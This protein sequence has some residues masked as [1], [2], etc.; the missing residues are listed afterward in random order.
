LRIA[1]KKRIESGEKEPLF[2][3]DDYVY[4]FFPES[5]LKWAE[6]QDLLLFRIYEVLNDWLA[7][8]YSKKI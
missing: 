4:F 3:F 2:S 5:S 1:I 6:I 7:Q 8:L